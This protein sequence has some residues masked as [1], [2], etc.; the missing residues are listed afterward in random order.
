VRRELARRVLRDLLTSRAA[1]PPAGFAEAADRLL[2]ARH[3][4]AYEIARPH[5]AGRDVVEIGTNRG[6]GSRLLRPLARSFT[7]VDLD[8]GHALAARTEG[9]VRSIQADGQRLPLRGATA[10]VVVSF[11]V[12]EHVW[13]VPAFLREIHRILRPGGVFVVSTPH[14]RGRLLPWQMP[15]NE[16]HLREYDAGS[17]TRA[18]GA[19]FDAVDPFGL[20]ADG[21]V[22][23]I[24]QT[25]VEVDPWTHYFAGPWGGSLRFVGR[26]ARR[27]VP[28]RPEPTPREIEAV[29]V[30]ADDAL[31]RRYSPS[32]EDLDHALDLFAV[33]RKEGSAR[34]GDRETFDAPGYWR[35]RLREHPGLSGTGSSLAPLAWQTWLYRGKERAYSRLLRRASLDVRGADVL[36]FG[37]GTGHFEDL[38]ERLGAGATAG[39]DVVPETIERL[40]RAYPGR[41]YLCADLSSESA[42]LALFGRPDLITALDVLYHIV[43]DDRLLAVLRKLVDLLPSGGHFLFTDALREQETSPHVRFRSF[44][45]WMQILPAVSL[46]FADREP[47]F[48]LNNHFGGAAIRLPGPAGALQ[49]FFDPPILR[50]MPC[51]ANNWAVL[52]RK[53]GPG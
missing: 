18:L 33:C 31:V 28:R 16:E 9:G 25:R 29:R 39:I 7:G 50:T 12:I 52:A 27:I 17:F 2:H 44:N 4:A 23:A 32:H 30:A 24:E 13:S 1:D 45:Q 40:R 3:L 22:V 47:V 8:F 6:Y 38:W 42:D 14:A 20:V 11:Q 34:P 36:D 10:D 15:W 21:A 41:R 37:C 49:H 5:V 46:A 35:E 26:G 51:L 48:A 19:I 53:G 43:D